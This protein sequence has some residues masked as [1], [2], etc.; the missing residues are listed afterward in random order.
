MDP[1]T[2]FREMAPIFCTTDIPVEA[3]GK[4]MQD[5][6]EEKG[7]SQVR[8]IMMNKLLILLL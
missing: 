5:F 7:L 1:V 3:I 2:Y 6:V 4:T 8:E